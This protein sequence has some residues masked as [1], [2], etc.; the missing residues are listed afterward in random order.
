MVGFPSKFKLSLKNFHLKLTKKIGNFLNLIEML[1]SNLK[2]EVL[3]FKLTKMYVLLLLPIYH[4]NLLV[5]W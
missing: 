3:K 1:Q 4:Q 5:N 2:I